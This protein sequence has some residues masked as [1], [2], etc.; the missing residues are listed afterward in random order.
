MLRRGVW[1]CSH[2]SSKLL[3][4]SH[5]VSFVLGSK[6]KEKIIKGF[7][8]SWGFR[9]EHMAFGD[10][11]RCCSESQA[12]ICSFLLMT[13]F[14]RTQTS[15]AFFL[16]FNVLNY[17]PK[18]QVPEFLPKALRNR[19]RRWGNRGPVLLHLLKVALPYQVHFGDTLPNTACDPSNSAWVLCAYLHHLKSTWEKQV[20]RFCSCFKRQL[21]LQALGST[22]S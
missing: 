12:L 22:Q 21:R 10:S 8:N 14:A 15:T 4:S 2:H 9:A 7:T 13:K 5:T 19:C 20:H 18:S 3:F 17:R 1:L 11:S 6:R 16:K